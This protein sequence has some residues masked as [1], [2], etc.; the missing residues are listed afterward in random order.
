[1]FNRLK[2]KQT[3]SGCQKTIDR[4]VRYCPHC[5]E[6]QSGQ[7]VT[8]GQCRQEVPANARFCPGCGA[9]M[10]EVIAP[11]VRQN[12]WA[13]NANDLAIRIEV[14]D[15][16]GFW[17][18]KLVVEP[19]TQAIIM[20]DGRNL[21]V[22]G[23]GE[24]TLENL[25]DKAERFAA[26]RVAQRMTAVIVDTE[27]F[28]MQ[29]GCGG[30]F[31]N[32][33][34][35]VGLGVRL[36][37]QVKEPLKF[38]TTMLRSR[39]RFTRE[40]LRQY[41]AP[42]IDNAAQAWLGQRSAHDLAVRLELKQELETHLELFL[43]DTFGLNGLDFTR[44]RTMDYNLEHIDRI[45]DIEET[46]LLRVTEMDT[47]LAGRKQ[48]FEVFT[49]EQLQE[50]AEETQKVEIYERRAKLRERMRQ[51]VLSDKFSEL[52]NE[53]EMEQ[54]LRQ[55]DKENL[56]AD[57]EWD[58][59]KRTLHWQRD[60][61]LRQRKTELED[62][63]WARTIDLEDRERDRAH[64]LARLNL[65][66]QH[67]LR[68]IQLLQRLDLEPAELEHEQE[69]ARQQ[70]EGEIAL[71][72]LK[73]EFR[74]SQQAQEANF[75]R[76][77][78][79]LDD[80]SRRERA[81]QDTQNRLTLGLQQAQ[82]Q[83]EI[84]DIHRQQ[85]QADAE[86]GILLLEKM[87]AVRRKDEEER[88]LQRLRS[89]ERDME[90]DLRAEQRR[91][92]MELQRKEVDYRHEL[93]RQAQEQQFELNWMER[94]KGMTPA[95][96]I[97]T[98]RETDRAQLIRDMQQTE[99]MKGMS[100]QQILATMSANSPDA[101]QALAELA[102]AAADGRFGEEQ[103]D[104]Y[105]RMMAQAAQHAQE[106]TQR[107]QAETERMERVRQQDL[108]DRQ[109]ERESTRNIIQTQLGGMADIERAKAGQPGPAGPTV[110]VT[111]TGGQSQTIGGSV[112]S[113]G[114]FR[115]PKCSQVVEEGANFCPNCRHQLRGTANS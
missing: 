41:L 114:V 62:R 94:L 63:D 96:L 68:Q 40:D 85:D 61:E 89:K 69:M 49:Q 13:R 3:C 23:P 25:I 20:A 74:L 50:L 64:L 99:A 108:S 60:D 4:D 82:N 84:A 5:G 38:Y 70:L 42:E 87:K 54:F 46:Y 102:R 106:L 16:A 24:Y 73:Q 27:P 59:F 115:C 81:L 75:R 26:L 34:L 12:R 67:D 56:I 104:M 100:E 43:G 11:A 77:Q 57:D 92:E 86:L 15:V 90:L 80:I 35:R 51:A 110:V 37:A 105:E 72:S 52:E 88:E 21:G 109:A 19:G 103:R 97:V 39:V 22:Q 107:S 91:L 6:A 44:L 65:E 29:F 55:M 112:Q 48:V 113:S 95:E 45:K 1:M 32:D 2:G 33:P 18:H 7:T 79:N 8:C 76:E 47:E 14:D 78:Q 101:A 28:E 71:E 9:A 17:S 31:T 53:Q 111:G 10:S 58:R 66:Q 30:I 98:A 36:L 93:E 83:A